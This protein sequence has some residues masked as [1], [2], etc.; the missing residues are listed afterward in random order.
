[1]DQPASSASTS[2]RTRAGSSSSGGPA[3]SPAPSRE[4][5]RSGSAAANNAVQSAG[6]APSTANSSKVRPTAVSRSKLWTRISATCSR[7]TAPEPAIALGEDQP[8]LP[9]AGHV[10]PARRDDRVG[11]AG[12]ADQPF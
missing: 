9:R 10:E 7:P 2:R 1:M 12:G 11:Q 6:G 8:V 3:E 4:P 5:G